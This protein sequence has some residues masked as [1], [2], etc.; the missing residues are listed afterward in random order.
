MCTTRHAVVVI[1]LLISIIWRGKV[2]RNHLQESL[3]ITTAEV[4]EGMT[5]LAASEAPTELEAILL[6]MH[7]CV[8]AASG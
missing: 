5:A 4:Q 1:I 6:Y 2:V 7:C 3:L 8:A